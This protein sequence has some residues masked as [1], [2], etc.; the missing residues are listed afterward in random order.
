MLRRGV[1]SGFSL[2]VAGLLTTATMVAECCPAW[3][4]NS[5][6][7][8]RRA[9]ERTKFSDEE[10]KEGL[11]KTAFRPEL[12]F[13]RDEE[14]IRKFDGPV[15]VFIENQGARERA[16]QIVEILKDM[17]ARIKHLD[18]VET[19][20]RKDANVMVFLVPARNFARTIRTRYGNGAADKI[21]NALHPQCLSGIAK[22]ESYRIRRAEVILPVDAGEFQ[23]YD[24][25]YEE[26]LQSLGLINDDSSVPWTMF[27]DSVQMGFFDVYDQYLANLLYDPRIRP[28]MT[29]AEVGALLPDIFP[30]VR[31]WVAQANSARAKE[32][33][34]DRDANDVTTATTAGASADAGK[35]R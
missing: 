22:D 33:R 34:D 12:Q 20:D 23:F 27:N 29:K 3:A 18:L 31:T 24:C 19:S 35:H 8:L 11:F 26:L 1:I 14:R 21:Q 10:I 4:E 17:R 7:S 9:T 15:R 30:A 32:L 25:A 6:I 13:G 16:D 28:G 2:V 5:A